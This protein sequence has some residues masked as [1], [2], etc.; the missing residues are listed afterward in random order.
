MSVGLQRRLIFLE[1]SNESGRAT[2]RTNPS[3]RARRSQLPVGEGA[4][5]GLG[6]F[7][8]PIF[9]L[10]LLET[11]GGG[12]LLEAF[13]GGGLLLVVRFLEAFFLLVVL[14]LLLVVPV[15]E[16]SDEGVELLV[17]LRL[18]RRE[19]R[20]PSGRIARRGDDTF[21]VDAG[22]EKGNG[23]PEEVVLLSK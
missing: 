4:P 20:T 7:D 16:I 1:T 8:F 21:C 5:V 10:L 15:R 11:F 6:L 17:I 2:L 12:L 18:A 9:F 23:G 14:L 22:T 3:L 19:Q 13:G